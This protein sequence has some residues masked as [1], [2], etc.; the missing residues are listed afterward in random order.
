MTDNIYGEDLYG[1]DLARQVECVRASPLIVVVL[2]PTNEAVVKRE[3]ARGT[4]AYHDRMGR[5]T[6]E[7]AVAEFQT[8]LAATP[9]IGLWLDTTRQGPAATVD[10]ILARAW[11]EGRVR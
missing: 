8:Y 3:L 10:A 1:E 9:R 6:L 2:N 5:Q 7:S 11:T 4:A